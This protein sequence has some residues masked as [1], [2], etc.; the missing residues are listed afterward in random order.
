MIMMIMLMVIDDADQA[1]ADH[2]ISCQAV[3]AV[4]RSSLSVV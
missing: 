3:H 2:D 1:A 4:R